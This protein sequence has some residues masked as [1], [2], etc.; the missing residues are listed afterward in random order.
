[1]DQYQAIPPFTSRKAFFAHVE[2]RYA[3]AY[4]AWQEAL[5]GLLTTEQQL[6]DLRRQHADLLGPQGRGG[7]EF[8]FL[9]AKLALLA[10]SQLDGKATTAEQRRAWVTVELSKSPAYL[11]LRAKLAEVQGDVAALEQSVVHIGRRIQVLTAATRHYDAWITFF[12]K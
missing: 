12:A 3:V 10:P 6:A 1:M 8:E 5:S 2:D 4:Q 11:A 7:L 9:E